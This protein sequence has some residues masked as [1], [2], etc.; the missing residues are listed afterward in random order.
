MT[1]TD[2]VQDVLILAPPCSVYELLVDSDKHV[3]WEGTEASLDPRPGGVYRV[4][5]AGRYPLVGHFVDAIPCEVVSLTLNWDVP[6]ASGVPL[7]IEYRLRPAFGQRTR[8]T[9][10]HREIPANAVDDV[11]NASEHY[12]ARLA[13]VASG[14]KLPPDAPLDEGADLSSERAQPSVT[15]PSRDGVE[16]SHEFAAM[17]LA[18]DDLF[19]VLGKLEPDDWDRPT[20]CAPLN[21]RDLVAHIT[22]SFEF[23]A[24]WLT[25]TPP[26]GHAMLDRSTMWRAFPDGTPARVAEAALS[27]PND[28]TPTETIRSLRRAVQTFI[29]SLSDRSVDDLAACPMFGADFV[30]KAV[31][32][33]ANRVLEVGVHLLDVLAAVGRPE[34][35]PPA[36]E[37]VIR[38]ILDGLLGGEPPPVLRWDFD[39]YVL[40]GTGRLPLSPL[41]REQLGEGLATRFP[42][43]A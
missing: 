42:L 41:E 28:R 15:T 9:V 27:V 24:T 36:C 32:V 25:T 26:V 30:L 14:A 19:D 7:K 34:S 39:T 35:L 1:A 22:G 16:A 11:R 31:D 20:R 13:A 43:L 37:P 33:M 2:I 21:V 4:V 17:Q 8:L 6:G 12:L 40:K 29:A 5:I 3:T 38:S 18:L 23:V 10:V